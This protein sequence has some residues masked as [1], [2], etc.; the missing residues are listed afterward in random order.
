MPVGRVE[1]GVIKPRM[2]VTFAPIGLITEFKYVEM[3]HEALLE[4][5]PRDNVGFN[6]K[7]CCSEGS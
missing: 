4:V 1:M 6:V 7:E 3:H 5:V 2:G